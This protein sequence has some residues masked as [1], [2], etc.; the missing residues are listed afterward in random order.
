MENELQVWKCKNGH[1]IGQIRKSGRGLSQ[2]L[3]Y[4][5]A[6][7]FENCT[8]AEVDVMAVIEGNVMDICCGICGEVKTWVPGE[9]ALEKLLAHYR[10]VSD[11]SVA[12]R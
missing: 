12:I 2:L 9:A 5:Q 7:S 6:V 10:K 3:L 1:A 4:R 11:R 8:P